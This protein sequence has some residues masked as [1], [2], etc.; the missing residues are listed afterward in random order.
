VKV[1][2]TNIFSDSKQ[3]RRCCPYTPSKVA[4]SPVKTGIAEIHLGRD[5][6]PARRRLR[7]GTFCFAENGRW[8]GM[9]TV[10]ITMAETVSRWLRKPVA[11][12]IK[13]AGVVS[14]S[15]GGLNWAHIQL[16]NLRSIPDNPALQ[17]CGPEMRDGTHPE[18]LINQR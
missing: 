7:R 8:N 10:H 2:E 5:A 18:L 3:T 13:V 12:L 6:L 9:N 15:G 17:R 1:G 11:Q 16:L 4:C 14:A